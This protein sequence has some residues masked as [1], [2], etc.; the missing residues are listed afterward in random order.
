MGLES[1]AQLRS[2]WLDVK[3]GLR[4]LRKHPVL[5]LAAVFATQWFSAGVT[6]VSAGPE[7]PVIPTGLKAVL[8]RMSEPTELMFFDSW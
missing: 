1:F 3:V 5:N 2:S 4:M 7:T 8:G 6:H